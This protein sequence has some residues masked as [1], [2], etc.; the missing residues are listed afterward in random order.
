[1]LEGVDLLP[2]RFDIG[3]DLV[4]VKTSPLNRPLNGN[5]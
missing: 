1:M 5:E 2:F 4:Q 3:L